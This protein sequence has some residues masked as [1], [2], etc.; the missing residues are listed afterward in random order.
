MTSRGPGSGWGPGDGWGTGGWAP[1]GSGPEDDSAIEEAP[2]PEGAP[3]APM[4]VPPPRLS[5]MPVTALLEV[6]GRI[7][8]RH[9]APL[10]AVSALFQLPSS[11]ADAAA[12]Q[13]LARALSPIVVGLDTDAPR[14]LEPTSAQS[15]AIL[16]ALMVVTATSIVACC[17]APSRHSPSTRAALDDYEGGGPASGEW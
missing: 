8:R 14:V 3:G 15:Q 9:V 11:I 5:P 6:A 1:G 13:R 7:I 10:L 17:W 4:D 12:Q 16:E 2:R